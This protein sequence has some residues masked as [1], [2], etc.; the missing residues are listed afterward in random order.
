VFAFFIA[1]V[2]GLVFGVGLLL[3]GMSNPEQMLAFLDLAAGSDPVLVLGMFGA[4]VFA[5]LGF[6]WARG[7]SHAITGLPIIL[8]TAT[9]L[10]RRLVVGGLVFGVGWGLAGICP[11]PSLILLGRGLPQGLWFVLAMIGGMWL[12]RLQEARLRP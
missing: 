10:E 5:V 4:N 7:R 8:P 12:H 1:M 2:L 6:V 11:G 3:S 9:R